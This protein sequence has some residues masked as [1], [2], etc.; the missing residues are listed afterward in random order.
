MAYDDPNFHVRREHFAGESGGAA[1]TEYGKFRVFQK[2]RL[3]KVH[4]V[5][6][7]AG[8]ATTHA[9]DIYHGTDSIGSIAISTATAGSQFSSV[10]LDHELDALSQI[11]V[12]TK[13]DAAGKNH[14][15]YEYE[16]A[17]DAVES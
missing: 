13:A 4:A 9:L 6:T 11:S 12:K 1:T 15:I 7:T 5:V 17:S 10:L 14:V 2:S 3:K 16:V 8:T